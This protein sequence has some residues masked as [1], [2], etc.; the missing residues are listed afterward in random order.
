MDHFIQ[1]L[2]FLA[3]ILTVLGAILVIFATQSKNKPDK[4]QLIITSLNEQFRK[5][6]LKVAKTILGKRF[7]ALAKIECAKQKKEQ[8]HS[9]E[10]AF[11]IDFKGDMRAKTVTQ[12]EMQISTLLQLT[13]A[14]DEIIVKLHSPGGTVNGYGLGASILEQI[15][16]QGIKLTV[17]VDEV[18]AS[19]GYMM[20]SVAN[21]ILAAPFA[22]IGSIGVALEAMNFNQVLKNHDIGYEQI[23]AGKYKRTLSTLGENT[24]SSR[25]KAKQDLEIIHTQFKALIQRHRPTVDIDSVATGEVWLGATAYEKNLVDRVCTSN[26]YICELIQKKNVYHIQCHQP[27][28]LTEKLTAG[29]SSVLDTLIQKIKTESKGHYE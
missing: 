23:T 7:K 14:S 12:L 28:K 13:H 21:Q 4:N 24:P 27:K 11:V 3:K 15:R 16:T 19:G 2:T 9:L 1:Y 20:A 29:L 26:E 8:H 25:E 18:A 5:S 17:C 10:R 22:Y 6:K